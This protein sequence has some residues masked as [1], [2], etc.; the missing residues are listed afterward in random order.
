QKAVLGKRYEADSRDY[1]KLAHRFAN[2]VIR[3]FTGTAGIF[4]SPIVFV[5]RVGRFKDLFEM[6]LDGSNLRQLTRERGLAVS[7]SFSSDGSSVLYTSY[8]TRRPDIWLLPLA[9]GAPRQITN[10]DGLEVS[11]K[12]LKSGSGFISA[13]TFDGASNI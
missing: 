12:F 11:A 7:P 13:A 5:S 4:G 9:G 6:D 2:E 8:R 10:R 3:Y 1:S